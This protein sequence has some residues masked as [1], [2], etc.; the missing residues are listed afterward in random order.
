MRLSDFKTSDSGQGRAIMKSRCASRSF[1]VVVVSA[2]LVT[3][4]IVPARAAR[5]YRF[6]L[7]DLPWAYPPADLTSGFSVSLAG[8]TFTATA[9]RVLTGETNQS[10][11]T[12]DVDL[13]LS[14]SSAG[15]LC[16][17]F[18]GALTERHNVTAVATGELRQEDSLVM[19]V[20]GT[21]CLDQNANLIAAAGDVTFVSDTYVNYWGGRTHVLWDRDLSGTGTFGFTARLD[22]SGTAGT[23][24]TLVV[25]G[26]IDMER[27]R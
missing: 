8:N 27:P 25:D 21:M 16:R 6:S 22:N 18:D 3:M 13:T 23:L 20:R 26:R 17:D 7:T 9:L 10:R 4:A 5:L 15:P 12:M 24:E 14:P 1:R 2:V 11:W 19:T